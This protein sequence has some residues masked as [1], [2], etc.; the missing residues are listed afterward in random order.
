MELCP[1]EICTG[2]LAC[3]NACP[4]GA[5]VLTKDDEGFVYPTIISEQCVECSLCNDVCPVI[6][7][8][9]QNL[10]RQP[11]ATYAAWSNEKQIVWKSSSG[12]LFTAIA[13]WVLTN[14]GVVYGAAFDGN[15]LVK[16]QRVDRI[17]DLEKL[18]GSKYVQSCIGD[19]FISVRNDLKQDRWV[20]FCGTPCQ[21]AGLQSYLGSNKEFAKLITI[22]IVCH[23]VPTSLMFDEYKSYLERKF[24]SKMTSYSFRDK[25]WSWMHYNTKAVFENG[26][27]YVGKWEE[28]IYMR[29]FLRE[30]FLRSSCH[31]CHFARAQ[32]CGDFTLADFWGYSAKKREVADKD[33]GVSMVLV[34]TEKAESIIAKIKNNLTIYPRAMEEA[35]AGNR[36]LREPSEKSPLREVFWWDYKMYGYK[37]LIEKY[38]YPE[39]IGKSLKR[40]YKFGRLIDFVYRALQKMKNKMLKLCKI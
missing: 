20:L 40:L 30:Y 8:S 24:N 22:D 21:I 6:D 25:K 37:S 19:N 15:F 36:C 33:R 7:D 12:G 13:E 17:D 28:D 14:N 32:R 31:S 9:Y 26:K 2:C 5:I 35:V 34:N 10:L 38:F 16:H 4:H 1:T 18:R 27:V 29:G 3:Y 39:P 23:G 11:L